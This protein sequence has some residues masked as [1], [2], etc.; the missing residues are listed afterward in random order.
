MWHFT[1]DLH[2]WH[3]WAAGQRGFTYTQSHDRAMM[4]GWNKAVRPS[5][6]VVVCG[7]MFWSNYPQVERYWKALNGTKIMVKGNHDRW[8]KKIKIPSKRIYSKNIKRKE[9]NTHVVACHYPILSWDRKRY[10]ALHVHGHCHGKLLPDWHRMD[11][12]V[13]VAYLMFGEW[14]PFSLDEVNYLLKEEK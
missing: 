11:V 7:D 5:D 4:E 14:R 1:A 2:I 9:G 10:G 3:P 6:V 12:G 8:L 13:D